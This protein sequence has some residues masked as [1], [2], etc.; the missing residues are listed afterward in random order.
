MEV[1]KNE[2]ILPGELPSMK[3]LQRDNKLPVLE[4]GVSVAVGKGGGL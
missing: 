4:L 1:V 2:M 3:I